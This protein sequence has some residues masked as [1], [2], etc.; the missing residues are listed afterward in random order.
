MS[1]IKVNTINDASGGSNAILY[2]VAAPANSMGFRNRIINGDM[3]IDQRY[4]GASI[5]PL[6]GQYTL[7]RWVGFRSQA[8]KFSVQQ[9]A[10]AV[11][12]PAGFTNYAGVVSLSAYSSLSGDYFGFQQSIEGLNS[13]DLGFGTTAAQ[14]VT[15]SFWVRSSLT[16]TLGGALRN[17]GNT[18]NFCFSYSVAAA[19][20]WEFKKITIPGDTT[21]TWVTNN[22]L[23]IQVWFDLGSGSSLTG[24]TGSWSATQIIRP[25]GSVSLVGT[26][27]ATFYIT[28]VQLEAGSVASPFERRDYGRELIMC[29]RYYFNKFFSIFISTPAA[30]SVAMLGYPAYMRAA[31]T[32]TGVPGYTVNVSY[33]LLDSQGTTNTRVV[34]GS[35]VGGAGEWS[36]FI[37]AESEF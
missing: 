13:A 21:G 3:R 33:F 14:A 24:A 11:T 9:N 28:G 25:T 18:R 32:T 34:M 35:T 5:T 12:P 36:G 15:L 10:G 1:T 30:T 6:D 31:P 27:G 37:S 8:S 20:T 16:G 23:G 7:D 19:N 26:N 29:Q 17:S 2:G 22:G 4:G